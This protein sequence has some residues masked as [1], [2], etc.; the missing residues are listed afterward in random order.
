VVVDADGVVRAGVGVTDTRIYPRSAL[1]P[2]QA[3]ASL[4]LAGDTPPPVDELAVMAASHTG[5]RMHQGV[6]L[7]LLGRAGVTPGALRCP[8]ALPSD[9]AALRERP[10]PTRLAHNCSGKHAGFLLA[11]QYAGE[12]PQR[13]LAEDSRVQVAVARWLR[14]TCG[15]VPEG[16]AVDGCGAPAWRLP[17]VALAR[18]YAR[19][20]SQEGLLG[21]I[22]VA[23]RTYPQLVGGSGL[24]DT[25][26]MSADER[27][28]AK[29]GAEATLGIAV[30]DRVRT[31]GVAIKVSDGGARAL[32]PIAGAVLARLGVRVP[33]VVARPVVLGGERP[34]GALETTSTL[35]EALAELA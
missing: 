12:D 5:S 17:L 24:V 10:A 6:V 33:M 21:Q 29:R 9:P 23:M 31:L 1:K 30:R 7:R 26:I 27:V 2:F 35:R 25:E 11:T 19:L 34:H 28:T 20:A 8:H 18:G 32:G 4:E 16:P 22:A 15:A 3:V 13:Y 14:D